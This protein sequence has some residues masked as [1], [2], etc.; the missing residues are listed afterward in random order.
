M[1]G[2]A[3]LSRN[4]IRQWTQFYDV[5]DAGGNVVGRR[6]IPYVNVQPLL[7]PNILVSQTVDYFP[8]SRVNLGAT[9]RYV[10]KAQLDNTNN[11]SLITPSF[12]TGDASADFRVSRSARLLVQV[13]NIFNRKHVFPSGY[14][15]S[16]ITPAGAVDGISYFYPQATRN[17][18]VSLRV[19][20]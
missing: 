7:T 12:F 10:G 15:Y 3:N 16:F 6:P 11:H 13:N 5:Y 19:H 14:S 9:G 18:L 4:R 2:S 8:S 20:L 17:A 1:S